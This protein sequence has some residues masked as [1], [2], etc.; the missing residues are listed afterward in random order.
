MMKKY[1][2]LLSC[3]FVST[4][5]N[6][7]Q[8]DTNKLDLYF[9]SLEKA[10]KFMG[11]VAVSKNEKIIYS[12]SIGYSNFE[13][14]TRSNANTKY[15]IGSIS[16]TF[17]AVLIMKAV[18]EKKLDLAQH[19]DKFFPSLTNASAITIGHLLSHRSGVHDFTDDENY[20]NWCYTPKSEKEMMA[21]IEKGGSNFQPDTKSEYSNSN[22]VLLTY[23]LEK[24]YKTPY[25]TLLKKCITDPFSLKNTYFGGSINT[26]NNEA[27]SYTFED[28]WKV[29][30][31]TDI[32]IPLGAGGIVS[33]PLDL[34]KFSDAL[35][36][37]KIL[38]A[39]SLALM[40]NIQDGHG[41]GLFKQ[42][43]YDKQGFGHRGGIDKFTA[44][45]S[46]FPSDHISFA[47]TSNGSNYNNNE[48]AVT[49]LNAI[50]GKPFE[51]PEFST[52]Q[53]N[54][55][56]LAKYNGVYASAQIPIKITITNDGKNL[57]A[58][59]DGQASMQLECTAENIFKFDKAG[60]VL[61]FKPAENVMILKQGGGQYIFNKEK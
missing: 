46:Y 24:T 55:E 27:K 9:S 10:N 54:A 33:N 21:F 38:K 29:A 25:A 12:R 4:L 44:V 49:V 51:I 19:I 26:S 6:A 31:E 3:F 40:E 8:F 34:I 18:E 43:F 28:N 48:V 53:I 16:K 42:P 5:T 20:V 45:F 39:E 35:F 36:S 30:K 61:E 23:I 57:T 14:N 13:N 56:E 60:I 1:L 37:G 11:T 15:R 41:L 17:T 58:Q 32:S 59:A 50:F 52:Y 7:Q 22:Y 47:L 2:F